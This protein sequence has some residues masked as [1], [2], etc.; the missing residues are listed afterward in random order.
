MLDIDRGNFYPLFKQLVANTRVLATVCDNAAEV[1]SEEFRDMITGPLGA[2]QAVLEQC[3]DAEVWDGSFS[4][5]DIVVEIFRHDSQRFGPP[6]SAKVIHVPTGMS[7]E[8]YSKQTAEENQTVARRALA[9]RVKYEWERR[10]AQQAPV[11]GPRPA[12]S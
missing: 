6:I 7:V 3:P 11:P 1:L 8:S 10:Q 5:D 12:R 9:E 2:V 4:E